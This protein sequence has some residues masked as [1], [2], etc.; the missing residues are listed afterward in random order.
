MDKFNITGC[1]SKQAKTT[2][3]FLTS[4]TGATGCSGKGIH[5]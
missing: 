2:H 4:S 1:Y 5:D 3:S